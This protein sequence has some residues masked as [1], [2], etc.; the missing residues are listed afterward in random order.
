MSPFSGFN[1][2]TG[3]NTP[4]P[5][6]FFTDLLPQVTD[7]DE[8]RVILWAFKSLDQQQGEMRYLTLEDFLEAEEFIPCLGKNTKEQSERLSKALEGAIRL[9][10]ILKAENAD[11]PLYFFNSPRGRAAIEALSQGAWQP[12]AH[13]STGFSASRPNIYALYEQ[14]IGLITPLIADELRDAE[15]QYPSDWINDAIRLAV[16]RNARNWRYIEAI[17]RSWKEKGRDER[18]QRSTQEDRKLDSEGQYGDFILH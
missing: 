5:A 12:E 8:L 13:H 7:L 16:T 3:K 1:T 18:D 9:G 14:N 15:N 11:Q 4:I 2:S 10:A 6:A 17:L